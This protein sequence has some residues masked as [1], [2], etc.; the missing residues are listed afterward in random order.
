MTITRREFFGLNLKSKSVLFFIRDLIKDVSVTLVPL[1]MDRTDTIGD[2]KTMKKVSSPLIQI[3]S[4][5]KAHRKLPMNAIDTSCH[6]STFVLL[7]Y[8][9]TAVLNT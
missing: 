5:L 1:S 2:E 6:C 4:Q 3:V 7:K 8:T 9:Q